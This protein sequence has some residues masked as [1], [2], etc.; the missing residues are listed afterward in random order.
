[1]EKPLLV[2]AKKFW[3]EKHRTRFPRIGYWVVTPEVRERIAQY[4]ELDSM[5]ERQIPAKFHYPDLI[6]V[7][8]DGVRL[9]Q[10]TPRIFIKTLYHEL[11]HYLCQHRPLTPEDQTFPEEQM[12]HEEEA[13]RIGFPDFAEFCK[14]N[15]LPKTFIFGHFPVEWYTK[16]FGH[17]GIE[18]SEKEGAENY[19]RSGWNSR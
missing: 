15:R 7:T 2:K 14:V 11:G 19:E 6:L 17:L 5:Y 10:T 16:H 18:F 8:A 12:K 13:E 3:I 9:L 1:M 4:Y